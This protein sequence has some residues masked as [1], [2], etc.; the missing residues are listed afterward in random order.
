MPR[1]TA[2]FSNGSPPSCIKSCAR[3]SAI[4]SAPCALPQ[5]SWVRPGKLNGRE[6]GWPQDRRPIFVLA[7]RRGLPFSRTIGQITR[8]LS[9]DGQH[10]EDSFLLRD[11]ADEDA[12]NA[13]IP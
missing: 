10:T 9:P 8:S 1:V 5:P 2:P 13:A 7:V 12:A 11:E 4:T 3:P 6:Y